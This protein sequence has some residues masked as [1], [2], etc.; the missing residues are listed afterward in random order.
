MPIDSGRKLFEAANEP[1]EFIELKDAA[2]NDL[3][4]WG[5][6]QTGQKIIENLLVKSEGG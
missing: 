3:P 5:S 6:L 4:D 2:H 1:K